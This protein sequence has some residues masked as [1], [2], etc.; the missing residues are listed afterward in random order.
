MSQETKS[1]SESVQAAVEEIVKSGV[2]VADRVAGL[3]GR[4]A[5]QAQ[6]AGEDLVHVARGAVS[7]AVDAV[8]AEQGSDGTSARMFDEVIQGLGQGF[9][10]AAL[11][12][13]L[14]L[15]EAQSRGKSFAE[16]DLQKMKSDLETLSTLYAETLGEGVKKLSATGSE[17]LQNLGEHAAAAA[18]RLKPALE[19]AIQALR[20]HPVD[21]A[22][23]AATAG[24]DAVLKGAG[25]LF[26]LVGEF[27]S[28]VGNKL[29]RS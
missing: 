22:T 21:T 26:S 14:A 29:N 10:N 12:A 19:A 9:S 1:G 28:G 23:S 4:A 16:T 15:E 25:S 7:G 11:T 24:S 17:E 5:A 18:E 8:K 2:G 27:L 20:D 13:R 6:D 3:I